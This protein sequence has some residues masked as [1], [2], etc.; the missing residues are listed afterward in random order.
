MSDPKN[1][2]PGDKHI[3]ASDVD[4]I[5]ITTDEINKL[6][7]VRDGFEPV[8]A[9]ILNLKEE[10]L[11]RAGVNEKSVGQLAELSLRDKRI[12]QLLPAVEKLAELLHETKQLGRHEIALIL[13]EISAQVRRRA[14]RSA[15]GAAVLGPFSDLLDY[16]YGPG[17]KGAATREKAK[18]AKQESV[19]AAPPVN[20]A[21]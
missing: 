19:N 13:A 7:K 20:A 21:P 11:D 9:S 1:P 14:E 6:T 8:I 3:D 12:G 2:V 18:E 5:D 17:A 16:Q 15:K 4:L 10:D